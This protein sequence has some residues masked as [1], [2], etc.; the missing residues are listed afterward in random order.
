MAQ[1]K[2]IIRKIIDLIEPAFK[3]KENF[4]I[5]PYYEYVDERESFMI[6]VGIDAV[7]QVNP[8]FGGLSV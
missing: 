8:R 2:Q 3:E 7:T 6:V 4:S 1:E 5:V